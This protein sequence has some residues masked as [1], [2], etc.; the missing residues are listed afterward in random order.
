MDTATLD[1]GLSNLH[2]IWEKRDAVD[3]MVQW[4]KSDPDILSYL[5][6]QIPK[7]E[8]TRSPRRRMNEI[9]DSIES[10]FTDIGCITYK[11]AKRLGWIRK[12]D[13]SRDFA[14]L[15]SKIKCAVKFDGPHRDGSR[16]FYYHESQDPSQWTAVPEAGPISIHSDGLAAAEAFLYHFAAG[17]SV[18]WK[19]IVTKEKKFFITDKGSFANVN[20]MLA[21]WNSRFLRPLM[22]RNGWIGQANLYKKMNEEE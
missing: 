15:M 3:I 11:E 14:R 5:R 12:N 18:H 20:L 22:L 21:D 8:S 2:S 16:V 7:E 19:N 9:A 6:E 4:A 13:R 17:V 1:E 10:Q